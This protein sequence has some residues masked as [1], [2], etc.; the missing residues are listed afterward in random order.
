[1]VSR[2]V[3]K[4][5]DIYDDFFSEDLINEAKRKVN[6]YDYI[7]EFEGYSSKYYL[8][9][10]GNVTIGSGIFI[11]QRDIVDTLNKIMKHAEECNA[12]EICTTVKNLASTKT[13]DEK[14]KN[15]VYAAHVSA[16][17]FF[18]DYTKGREMYNKKVK[19]KIEFVLTDLIFNMGAK[20]YLKFPQFVLKLKLGI[21]DPLELM[22]SSY[23]MVSE[24]IVEYNKKSKYLKQTKRR[25]LINAL[26]L[27]NIAK[28][29][30]T[31]FQRIETLS[32]KKKGR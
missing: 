14:F 17:F 26:R 30:D 1:M 10:L 20:W 7:R 29:R 28:Q 4:K 5:M 15:A 24:H 19:E 23:K 32:Y 21:I 11:Q 3:G 22:F 8:D 25:A 13:L 16:K 2:F 6:L 18:K 31:S 12:K 9:T 27:S